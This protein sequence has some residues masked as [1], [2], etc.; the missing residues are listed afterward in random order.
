M[1]TIKRPWGVGP[2]CVVN[3]RG[4]LLLH[5]R[6]RGE[7]AHSGQIHDGF[8]A[9]GEGDD[10]GGDLDRY[11]GREGDSYRLGSALDWSTAAAM[12]SGALPAWVG[13]L[14]YSAKP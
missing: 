10:E 13:A 12:T 4:G 1:R 5:G 3:N 9:G 11:S 6:Q 14:M 7:K 8:G 2:G